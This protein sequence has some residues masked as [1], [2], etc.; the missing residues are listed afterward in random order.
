M[1]VPK[2]MGLKDLG[3]KPKPKPKPNPKPKPKPKPFR[4]PKPKPKLKPKL[5]YGLG[6]KDLGLR[7]WP[8]SWD[9]VVGGFQSLKAAWIWDKRLLGLGL[10]F[11]CFFFNLGFDVGCVLWY[12]FNDSWVEDLEWG[13]TIGWV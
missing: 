11:A 13:F 10:G 12:V 9:S 4:V 3:P 5:Q 8:L 7:V 1:G 6:L 2:G